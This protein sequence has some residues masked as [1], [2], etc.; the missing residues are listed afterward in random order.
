MVPAGEWTSS[1]LIPNSCAFGSIIKDGDVAGSDGPKGIV[2]QH[3][4]RY[5]Q[6]A[7]QMA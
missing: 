6:M 2:L 3:L 5:A 7:I 1:D 4:V